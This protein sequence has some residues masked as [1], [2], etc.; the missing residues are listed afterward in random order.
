MF[1]AESVCIVGASGKNADNP[2]TIIINKYLSIP[3]A[4][5]PKITCIHPKE[6]SMFGCKCYKN[7]DELI[8][9]SKPELI[10][11]GTAAAIT[12]QYIEE[13]IVKQ[14]CKAVFT[15][16]GGFAETE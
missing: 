11:L 2:G 15:L 7:L 9:E 10:I 14:A 6:E 8:K 1:A 4:M 5:R 13:I 12:A 3:E 16:A